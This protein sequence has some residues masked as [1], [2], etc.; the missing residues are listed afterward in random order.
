MQRYNSS[1]IGKKSTVSASSATGIFSMN[2]VADERRL[3]NWPIVKKSQYKSFTLNTFSGTYMYFHSFWTDQTASSS[4][5]TKMFVA[6]D[7]SNNIHEFSITNDDLSTLS[8]TDAQALPTTSIYLN[9]SINSDGTK[10]TSWGRATNRVQSW[11]FSTA[12]DKS[13]VSYQ[14]FD[15]LGASGADVV[16]GFWYDNGTKLQVVRETAHQLWY[17][18]TAYDVSGFGTSANSAANFTNNNIK[19]VKHAY[20]QIPA[21][22]EASSTGFPSY[23]ALGRNTASWSD[24]Y[25]PYLMVN[26]SGTSTGY[27]IQNGTNSLG[28]SSSPM[29]TATTYYFKG[30]FVPPDGSEIWVYGD[31]SSTNNSTNTTLGRVLLRFKLNTAGT[32]TSASDVASF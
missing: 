16:G 31:T 10:L 28:G 1:I 20:H 17:T 11:E 19:A 8:Y 23:F 21:T 4:V 22:G 15:D 26:N 29:N 24:N 27:L 13:T 30:M 18:S 9:S 14:R 5:A 7:H 32:I 12:F 25:D 2:N 6:D 3:E